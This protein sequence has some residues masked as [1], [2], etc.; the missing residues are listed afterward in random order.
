MKSERLTEQQ[1][2]DELEEGRLD[3]LT[4]KLART[5][6][7]AVRRHSQTITSNVFIIR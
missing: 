6:L 3:L 1:F 5:L 4:G 7:S 2:I